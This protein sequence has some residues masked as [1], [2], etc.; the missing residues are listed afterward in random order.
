[1]AFSGPSSVTSSAMPASSMSPMP[2]YQ[3]RAANRRAVARPMP[4]AAP[5]MNMQGRDSRGDDMAISG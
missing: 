5:E 1:M 2:M 3:P 4:T